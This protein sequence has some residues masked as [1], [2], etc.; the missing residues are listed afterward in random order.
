MAHE[1]TTSI[2][3][4]GHGCY[5]NPS[6][7]HSADVGRFLVRVAFLLPDW[8]ATLY[9]TGRRFALNCYFSLIPRF[10]NCKMRFFI[11]TVLFAAVAA[12]NSNGIIKCVSPGQYCNPT[13]ADVVRCCYGSCSGTTDVGGVCSIC[14]SEFD[15]SKL[16]CLVQVCPPV[17]K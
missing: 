6:P 8:P 3:L 10:R 7:Y 2:R 17:G 4:S 11:L 5:N 15:F 9:K 16:I 14:H 13:I 12:Q 1:G